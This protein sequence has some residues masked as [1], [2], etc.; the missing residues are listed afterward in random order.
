MI[1][2]DTEI[3]NEIKES[4]CDLLLHSLACLQKDAFNK[5]RMQIQD[6]LIIA[7]SLH[8]KG[9]ISYPRT[10]SSY[11]SFNNAPYTAQIIN[12]IYSYIKTSSY[13]KIDSLK[14]II[15]I[16]KKSK[17]FNNKKSLKSEAIFPTISNISSEELNEEETLIL[18]LIC[19]RFLIQFLPTKND[20]SV[21]DKLKEF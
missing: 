20:F 19:V 5:H 21:I 18:N 10:D 16:D 13:I 4:D 3:I 7:E 1:N 8:D 11:I 15:N 9:Y 12:H 17:S 14:Q 2:L 6:T